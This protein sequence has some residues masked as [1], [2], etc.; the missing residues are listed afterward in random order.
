MRWRIWWLLRGS[1]R[2]GLKIITSTHN[3]FLKFLYHQNL[4]LLGYGLRNRLMRSGAK[5]S[6][7]LYKIQLWNIYTGTV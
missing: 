2:L 6:W 5:Q 4:N 1:D 3:T 7:A